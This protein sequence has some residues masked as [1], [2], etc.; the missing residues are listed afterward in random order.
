MNAIER[1]QQ[2]Q[3]QCSIQAESGG[4]IS[5]LFAAVL[6]FFVAY[7]VSPM[8]AVLGRCFAPPCWR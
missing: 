7:M 8:L 4:I 3:R 6:I 1:W 2:Q 5:G